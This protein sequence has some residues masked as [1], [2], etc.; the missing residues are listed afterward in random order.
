MSRAA[1]LLFAVPFLLNIFL[2]CLPA[3]SVFEFFHLSFHN[4]AGVVAENG[5]RGSPLRDE[6]K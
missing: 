3:L 5:L 4:G 6:T 2:T 1:A